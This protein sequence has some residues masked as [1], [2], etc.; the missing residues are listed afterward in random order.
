MAVLT[1]FLGNPGIKY[2]T[3]RHN[4]GKRVCSSLEKRYP[5][6]SWRKKFHSDF[7][8]LLVGGQSRTL[9]LCPGQYMNNSGTGVASCA[10]FFSIPIEKIL[11]VHD[12]LETPFGSF[13]FQKGGGLAG[14]NGLRSISGALGSNDFYR[15]KMGIGRP[16]RGTVSSYVLGRFSPLE[17]SQ[18]SDC[19]ESAVDLLCQV[20][21]SE[22]LKSQPIGR[23]TV[24]T[25]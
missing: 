6:I 12:D 2:K 4:Y 11:V 7:T 24:F 25:S 17:E 9:L 8:E 1:A 22:N 19:I 14:H 18:L 3:T 16:D 10:K 20:F 5:D 21:S 23:Y 15:L 13:V